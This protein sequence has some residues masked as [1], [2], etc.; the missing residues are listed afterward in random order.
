M[1]R[2][3]LLR[4]SSNTTLL[5]QCVCIGEAGWGGCKDGRWLDA[6]C[7][8]STTFFLA[9]TRRMHFQRWRSVS[10]IRRTRDSIQP[11]ANDTIT[12]FTCA[13][14]QQQKATEKKNKRNER[15]ECTHNDHTREKRVNDLICC[16]KKKNNNMTK[17]VSGAKKERTLDNSFQ[18]CLERRKN[19]LW[20]TVSKSVRSEGRPNSSFNWRRDERYAADEVLI[21]RVAHRTDRQ[22]LVLEQ[23]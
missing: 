8:T 5:R 17:R 14:Q 10:H 6:Y 18:V 16:L 19:K 13:Q 1:Q 21:Q 12:G 9:K 23:S 3:E 2:N 11:P 22:T 4:S 7:E 20:T 15:G